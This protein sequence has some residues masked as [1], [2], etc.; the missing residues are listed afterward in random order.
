MT[1]YKTLRRTSP[2]E[3]ERILFRIEL[4]RVIEQTVLVKQHI[5]KIMRLFTILSLHPQKSEISTY[6]ISKQMQIKVSLVDQ[7]RHDLSQTHLF[8]CHQT[9]L[10]ARHWTLKYTQIYFVGLI[11]SSI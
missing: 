9:N 3:E 2:T 6:D 8:I 4:Y 11:F 5:N 7:N 1:I 10:K